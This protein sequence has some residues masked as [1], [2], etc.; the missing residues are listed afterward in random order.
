MTEVVGQSTGHGQRLSPGL[1]DLDQLEEALDILLTLVHSLVV[2]G[3]WWQQ[4][5]SQHPLLLLQVLLS[6]ADVSPGQQ[7]NV[8]IRG[9][10][11]IWNSC[12]APFWSQPFFMT[13]LILLCTC[14]PCRRSVTSQ[15]TS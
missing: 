9:P 14:H 8:C 13:E 5:V 7:G 6:V 10:I 15:S 1:K 3:A 2:R 12:I 11:Y 4:A